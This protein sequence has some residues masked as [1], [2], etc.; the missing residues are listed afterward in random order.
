TSAGMYAAKYRLSSAAAETGTVAVTSNPPGAVVEIDGTPRGKTPLSVA[1]AVGSHSL[2][3]RGE[4]EPRTIPLSITAG[5]QL[6]QYLDLPKAAAAAGQLQ[7]KTV[8]AGARVS[9]DG[10]VQG[11]APIT[12]M[13]LTPG[14]HSVTLES[15][16]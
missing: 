8:P 12:V 16:Q 10:V 2:V 6:A 1:L 11:M 7:I 15:D 9:V 5:A 13:D 3:V 14:D 4:G